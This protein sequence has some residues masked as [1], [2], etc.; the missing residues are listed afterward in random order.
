M[1]LAAL[2]G[3]PGNVRWKLFHFTPEE[4]W[5][6]SGSGREGEVAQWP[7][8]QVLDVGLKSLQGRCVCIFCWRWQRKEELTQSVFW[9]LHVTLW[10]QEGFLCATVSS[11]QLNSAPGSTAHPCH[12]LGQ[13]AQGQ[14]QKLW[15]EHWLHRWWSVNKCV[16]ISELV[17][18]PGPQKG[19]KSFHIK[20]STNSQQF[21]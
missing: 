18:V 17:A 15:F 8:Y 5:C 11:A 6:R 13:E 7:R 3:C 4:Q 9:W 1:L 20:L 16:E 21:A 14:H 12:Q 10:L 2:S 19:T